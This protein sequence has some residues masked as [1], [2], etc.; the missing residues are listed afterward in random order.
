[1][2]SRTCHPEGGATSACRQKPRTTHTDAAVVLERSTR[3]SW[4]TLSSERSS[5]PKSWQRVTPHC[6][7][8]RPT[9]SWSSQ[10]CCPSW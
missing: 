3:S 2:S 4:T 8:C 1:M 5:P 10:S 6:G 9:D 7:W